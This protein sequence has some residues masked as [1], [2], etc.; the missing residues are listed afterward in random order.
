MMGQA[1]MFINAYKNHFGLDS[2]LIFYSFLVNI[3]HLLGS[4]KMSIVIN[5]GKDDNGKVLFL[6]HEVA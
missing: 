5:Y 2:G 4:G 6:I 3:M 1:E